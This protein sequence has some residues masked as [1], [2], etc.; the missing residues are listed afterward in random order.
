MA[1]IVQQCRQCQSS[2]SVEDW[3]LAFF[4]KMACTFG[5]KTFEIPLPT[6]CPNCR[7]QRRLAQANQL[8]L[9]KRK[10]DL[11]GKIIISNFHSSSPYKVYDQE[12]WHSD[13]WNPLDYGRDF[14]FKRPF[15]EQFRALS[16][17]VPR[18]ALHRAHYYDENANYTNYAGKNKNCY[19]IFDSDNNEDC[20]YSYS[21]GHSKDCMQ[22][23]RVRESELCYECIDSGR[24]YRSAFL[25]DCEGCVDS[26]FLKNCIGCKNCILCSNL[27][28]REYYIANEKVSKEEFEALRSRLSSH[29]FL[30]GMK[31]RFTQMKMN[32]PQKFMHGVRNEN[33]FGDYLRNCKNA[34]HCF[35]SDDL[36]DCKYVYQ[37][38]EWLK[39]AMDTQECGSSE[40]VYES[41]FSGYNGNNYMFCSHCLGEPTDMF[42][43]MYSPHSKNLFGCVSMTRQQYCVLNKKY[44]KEEYESLTARVI[45]H[46]MKTGEWGEFFPVEISPFSYNETLAQDYYPLHKEL[47]LQKGWKWLEGSTEEEVYIGPTVQIPDRLEDVE[48]GI[49]DQ[50]LR[51]EMSGQLYK[52]TPQEL[53]LYR[54]INLS[55][56]RR[57]FKQIYAEH[58]TL[59]NPRRIWMRQCSNCELAIQSTYAPDHPEKVFCENCYLKSL[60]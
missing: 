15:F 45:E 26:Y 20:F 16:L 3:D 58:L 13:K 44:T 9:Y 41:A 33:S 11:T 55:I 42:Y 17:E 36:W 37:A 46:M 24:C 38:Y 40:K 19:M 10:C 49:C 35:D 43:C 32:F 34:S 54:K 31:E 57:C 52:V 18:P 23:F 56:A 30:E 47:V 51:C 14:D 59:R 7:Q 29:E 4:K 6:L 8:N 50:I 39:D 5:D 60:Q 28:N 22:C 1:A 12:T 2:S 53:L 27:Q 48:E 21:I 25:Q